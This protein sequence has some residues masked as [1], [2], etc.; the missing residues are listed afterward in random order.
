MATLTFEVS[1]SLLSRAREVAQ[2]LNRPIEDVL[3]GALAI[4]IPDVHDAPSSV[5][6]ELLEMAFLDEESLWQIT[7]G[8]MASEEQ[9]ELQVLLEVKERPLVPQE[10]ERLQELRESYGKTMHR[11]ARAYA[12]LSLRSG[13]PLL[14]ALDVTD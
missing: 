8:E 12:L 7:K 14:A 3:V 10:Q 1:D 9:R 11:K 5:R 13:Q 2:A 4:G 6:Y